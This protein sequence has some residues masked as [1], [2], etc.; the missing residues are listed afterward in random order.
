MTTRDNDTIIENPMLIAALGFA[1]WGGGCDIFPAPPGEKKSYKSAQYSKGVKW[2]ATRDPEQ[3]RC[4]W[5][6]WP[7]A[8]IG[9]PT[10]KENGLWVLEADTLK[11]HSVDGIASLR[12]LEEKHGKLPPTLVAESPSGS[13]HYYFNWPDGVEIR[14]SASVIG[15][16]IDVRA[17]GGMVLAPPSVRGDGKYQWLTDSEVADAPQWLIALAVAASKGKGKSNGKDTDGLA[18]EPQAPIER[19]RAAFAVIP[20]DNL[21]WDDWNNRGLALFHATGGSDGGLAVFHAWSN[22]SKKYDKQATADRWADYKTCPPTRIGAGSVFHWADEASPRWGMLVGVPLEQAMKIGALIPLSTF[23]YEL[24]RKEAAEELGV[25]TGVLDGMLDRLRPREVIEGDD[26]GKQGSAISFPEPEPWPE[27]VDGGELLDDIAKAIGAHVI[28][29]ELSR[30]ACAL[31]GAH[32]FLVDC[33]MISPRL[34]F[35]SPT[36][37]CGKTT[38]L[39]VMGQLVLQPLPAANVSSSAVFR[40]IE[41]HRPTLLIDE[42]DSFLRDNEELRGVLNSG[43]RRG[44]GVLRTVAAG[45]DFEVRA[46]ST[47]APCAIALIGKLPDTLA[48]RSIPIVLTRRKQ[49]EP[50]T[51][52]RLDRV[53]HL[54]VLNQKL[55]RWAKDSAEAIARTEPEMPAGLYNRAA[56]NWR[57]L[58]AI[59]TVAGGGWLARGHKAALAGAGADVDE[60]SLLELLLGDVRDVFDGLTSDADRIP[61]A[62]LIDRLVEIVPRPWGEYGKSGKP[63]TQNKLARLFKPL[64]IVP[65]VI[66]I[67]TATPH[68][69]YRHQF[70]EAWERYLSP[71]ACFGGAKPQQRNNADG[72]GT[73]GPFQSATANVSVAVQ[74]ATTG[75]DVPTGADVAVQNATVESDVAVRKCEK[76]NND[77][78]CFGVA[79][80]D[81]QKGGCGEESPNGGGNNKSADDNKSDTGDQEAGLSSRRIREL[82]DWYVNRALDQQTRNNKVDSAELGTGL[83]QVLAEEVQPELVEVEFQ[84][85]MVEVFR[86]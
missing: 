28:M 42:A 7:D 38:A 17:E 44:G 32:T 41:A 58:L 25:R 45:D 4:D 36:K 14:N 72:M 80:A 86:I 22:K 81:P 57:P 18:G 35:T 53:E 46:F 2:G 49:S 3:I 74:S 12:A 43:H 79:V 60:L 50:V 47:Y 77:G 73:S 10:G 65:Q 71:L 61:S 82:A 30:Y 34:A 84:R 52:F 20:N 21:G 15:P 62:R 8:N 6:R 83:R 19:I 66:R 37:G 70:E 63:I 55:A 54:T 31:W 56:D 69:Y 9:V 76:P 26:D 16:G 68:G 78:L 13:L 51:S 48:D 27:P 24:K 29:S 75:T 1:E 67:G 5:Q 40:V 39:D 33:T 11:G 23:D 59:A 85:I 64:G